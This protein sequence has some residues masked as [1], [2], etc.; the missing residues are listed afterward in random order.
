[1]IPVYGC[2][3]ELS[4]LLR[5]VFSIGDN[6]LCGK[7]YNNKLLL[8]IEQ[9]HDDVVVVKPAIFIWTFTSRLEVVTPSCNQLRRFLL[10]SATC[11]QFCYF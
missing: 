3:F 6:C 4:R 10:W 5:N 1:M 9:H 11:K 2:D 7:L 8:Q